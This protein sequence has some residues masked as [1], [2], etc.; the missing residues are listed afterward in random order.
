[1]LFADSS[2]YIIIFLAATLLL[3]YMFYKYN[4]SKNADIKDLY[5]EGMD[6]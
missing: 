4:P 1:M 6:K 5:S 3:V 2:F